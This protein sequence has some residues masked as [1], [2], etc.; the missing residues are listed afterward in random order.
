MWNDGYSKE[1][2]WL[3]Y[4]N[5]Y[6]RMHCC[7]GDPGMDPDATSEDTNFLTA[8]DL[9]RQAKEEAAA[10][11]AELEDYEGLSRTGSN[12]DEYDNVIGTD[13]D[14]GYSQGLDY[15]DYVD[16]GV[17]DYQAAE[18]RAN[19]QRIADEI[20]ENQSAL[21]R[22]V[23]VTLDKEGNFVYDGA[24]A[25][26]AAL[27][28]MGKGASYL[29]QN[30]G[31]GSAISA[32][33][34][35]LGITEKEVEE[36]VNP[37][38]IQQT[39]Q[40]LTIAGLPPASLDVPIPD[41]RRAEVKVTKLGTPDNLLS[42]AQK[43]EINAI[44]ANDVNINTNEVDGRIAAED[45][46]IA[47]SLAETQARQPMSLAGMAAIE[48]RTKN[49]NDNFDRFDRNQET[50]AGVNVMNMD[51]FI[52]QPGYGGAALGGMTDA[53]LQEAFAQE[54]FDLGIGPSS[55][56]YAGAALGGMTDAELQAGYAQ[57]ARDM[58]SARQP[59]VLGLRNVDSAENIFKEIIKKPPEEKEVVTK[60]PMEKYFA[61]RGTP[62]IPSSF[63]EYRSY[64]P[65]IG[66]AANADYRRTLALGT[67]RYQEP[68]G[69][70]RSI[71]TLAA[72]YGLTYDEA[73]KRF[74]PPSVPAM[75]GGGL[76][77]L[78]EYS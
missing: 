65:P 67:P 1:Q 42:P 34:R 14:G 35:E 2:P 37:K 8:D 70:N 64:L 49:T 32:L 71:A 78:M 15:N 56:G 12:V 20:V 17:F 18:S 55:P 40:N 4:Y 28:E 51:D 53:E 54:A 24:D 22:A 77:S 39:A 5:S 44:M 74:A 41:P 30:I 68:S 13:R 76:R 26:T 50:L 66:P 73:A 69:P 23:D 52:Q 38:A 47:E 72:A 75:G 62:A 61:G 57:E 9:D 19:D 58:S 11:A 48:G 29:S 3:N 25:F 16:M 10:M 27:G 6:E 7:F 46:L 45:A 21:G 63:Q 33:A 59:D 60:T 31:I 43:A 36:Q